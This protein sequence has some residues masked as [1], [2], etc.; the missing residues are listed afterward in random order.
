M[1]AMNRERI[2]EDR[3]AAEQLKASYSGGMQK[4]AKRQEHRCEILNICIIP[5]FLMYDQ[6]QDINGQC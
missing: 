6:T 3:Q 2:T 1:V 4:R 5:N